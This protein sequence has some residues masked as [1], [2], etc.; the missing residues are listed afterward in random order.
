M[1]IQELT[2]IIKGDV[3]FDDKTLDVYSHDASVLEI[4]PQVVVFP[5]DSEDIQNLVDYVTKAK[6]TDPTI[7]LTARSAGTCMAGGSINDSIIV[8]VTKYMHGLVSVSPSEHESARLLH[9]NFEPVPQLGEGGYAVTQPGVYYRDFEK[10]TKEIDFILPSYTAS[11]DL[12]A[13][14]G[15]FGNN[16]GGEKTIK[17]GKCENYVLQTKT[18]FSDGNEYVVKP[19]T[20]AELDAKIAQRDFEGNL[21][22]EVFELI[23]RNYDMVMQARAKCNQELC[24]VLLVE[25]LG[26]EKRH[27]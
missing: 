26:Q 21:Y 14:G 25:C 6:E 16:S 22:R 5:K 4:R 18:I 1:N 10:K 12:C 9:Y 27:L 8:D 11:K 2:E 17:Y 13:V 24:R 7:S 19:L 3:L 15:M 23:D 20:K